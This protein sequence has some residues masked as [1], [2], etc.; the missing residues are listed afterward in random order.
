MHPD[1]TSTAVTDEPAVDATAEAAIESTPLA[2][3]TSKIV[4][5][6]VAVAIPTV[7][8][9]STAA[10]PGESVTVRLTGFPASSWIL[11]W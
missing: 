1:P 11:I 10:Q 5:L 4:E 3:E 9:S 8:F 6:S 2:D 7:V